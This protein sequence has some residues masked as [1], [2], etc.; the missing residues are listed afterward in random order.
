MAHLAHLGLGDVAQLSHLRVAEPDSLQ[1]FN[2]A[3][4]DLGGR[5]E[6]LALAHE[7]LELGEEPG[8]DSGDPVDLVHGEARL[9]GAVEL[10]GAFGC[11]GADR[12]PHRVDGVVLEA[13]RV[14]V[15]RRQP[16]RP[17]VLQRAETLE[18]R[19]LEGAADRH[20][21]AHGL[22][23]HAE[24]RVRLRELLEREARDLHDHVVEHRLEARRRHLRDR[25]RDLV[26]AVADREL[27]AD[28]RD[29]EAS[30]LG[31]ERRTP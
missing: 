23:L 29:R 8:V 11:R 28:A 22:H 20:H 17:P 15:R 6:G 7:F 9:E 4:R 30:R 27:G 13:V 18:P 5:R 19:L 12:G 16:P 10:E 26:E 24:R 1:T 25:V 3:G 2:V 14:G 21:L 31:R